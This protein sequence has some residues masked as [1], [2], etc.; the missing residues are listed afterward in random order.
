MFCCCCLQVA[1][2]GFV[3]RLRKPP[4]G[5][6]CD[7]RDPIVYE[8]KTKNRSFQIPPFEERSVKKPRFYDQETMICSFSLVMTD[9]CGRHAKP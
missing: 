6:F 9:E 8:T 1:H 5:S 3:L 7:H 4:S 2:F